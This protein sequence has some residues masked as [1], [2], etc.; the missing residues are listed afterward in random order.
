[1]QRLCRSGSLRF[2]A[3]TRKCLAKKLQSLSVCE[4]T[5]EDPSTFKAIL[6]AKPYAQLVECEWVRRSKFSSRW[7]PK[8]W[9]WSEQLQREYSQNIPE[10]TSQH[11]Y[12]RV[13]I[14][15]SEQR[16]TSEQLEV[17]FPLYVDRRP[18]LKI[19]KKVKLFEQKLIRRSQRPWRKIFILRSQGS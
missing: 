1:M 15:L 5:Q 18:L 12:W 9:T 6:E 19:R 11:G 3:T 17:F 16:P 8:V 7:N 13:K 14:S 2:K 10:E 4:A